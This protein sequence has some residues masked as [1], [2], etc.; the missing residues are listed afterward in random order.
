VPPIDI[1]FPETC[2]SFGTMFLPYFQVI[3]SEYAFGV[4]IVCP[5]NSCLCQHENP[6]KMGD[7][8][9]F[10]CSKN[11]PGECLSQA[12]MSSCPETDG[13]MIRGSRH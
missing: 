2:E 8:N 9:T 12:F 5:Q 7:G 6:S 3:V 13:S 11:L 10:A 1:G 4:R